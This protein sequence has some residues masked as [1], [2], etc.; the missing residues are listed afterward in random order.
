MMLRNF[1]VLSLGNDNV[2]DITFNLTGLG[3]FNV[4][5]YPVDIANQDEGTNQSVLVNVSVPD[6]YASGN[7]TGVI[8]VSSANGGWDVLDIYA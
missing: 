8:N 6:G 3:D 4:T 2:T 5:Y 1:T 7:Y